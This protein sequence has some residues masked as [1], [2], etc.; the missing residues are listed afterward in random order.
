MDAQMLVL[1]TRNFLEQFEFR[2]FALEFHERWKAGR[3]G[4]SDILY[5]SEHRQQTAGEI[6]GRQRII[7]QLFFEQVTKKGHEMLTKDEKRAFSEYERISIYRN[8]NGLCQICLKEG[9][10]RKGVCGVLARV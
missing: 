7:R 2:T 10:T 9:E 4:D 8:D 5:F 3:E 1:N 6:D